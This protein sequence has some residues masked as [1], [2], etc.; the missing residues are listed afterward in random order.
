MK[1]D[2]GMFDVEA[3]RE[4]LEQYSLSQNTFHPV[5][6]L[7]MPPIE[8]VIGVGQNEVGYLTQD[9]PQRFILTFGLGPCIGIYTRNPVTKAQTLAHISG[10]FESK[11]RA[12]GRFVRAKGLVLRDGSGLENNT[13]IDVLQSPYA[14]DRDVNRVVSTLEG[15]GYNNVKIRKKVQKNRDETYSIDV[16]YDHEG[17]ML[18]L[19]D[20]RPLE[21]G[22]I[23]RIKALAFSS[24]LHIYNE[25]GIPVLDPLDELNSILTKID[26]NTLS[27]SNNTWEEEKAFLKYLKLHQ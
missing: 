18:N 5:G 10:N 22:R 16:I 6:T 25:D 4:L 13:L 7:A 8:Q 3:F 1:F 12:F 11:T 9:M 17:M 27:S 14:S 19:T 20:I 23:E 26:F 15:F 2:P 24:H 21:D